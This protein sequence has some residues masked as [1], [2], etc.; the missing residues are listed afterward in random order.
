MNQLTALLLAPPVD[1]LAHIK[2]FEQHELEHTNKNTERM[3]RRAQKK[4][5]DNLTRDEM[6]AIE[7]D[8]WL[9]EVLHHLEQ[10]E[11]MTSAELGEVM[12]TSRCT[13]YRRLWNMEKG[14]HVKRTGT[15][16]TTRWEL[17][18]KEN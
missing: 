18:T 2:K 10:N 6:Q 3:R 9:A 13:A 5:G 17:A 4:R 14:G 12:G 15:S 11:S 16:V 7:R 1:L 8:K